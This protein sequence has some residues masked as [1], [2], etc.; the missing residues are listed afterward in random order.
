ML[1]ISGLEHDAVYVA[2]LA[3]SGMIFI[4]RKDG[5]SHNEFEDATLEHLEAG[6]NVLLH[7][8]LKRAGT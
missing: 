5:I 7:A 2:K 8:T 1:V 3:P 6:C 4:Q